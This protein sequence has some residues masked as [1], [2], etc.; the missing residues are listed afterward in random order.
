MRRITAAVR[1][2]L[3]AFALLSAAA[4]AADMIALPPQV[5]DAFAAAPPIGM[6][7]VRQ[8]YNSAVEN[9]TQFMVNQLQD[10]AG[11]CVEDPTNDWNMAFNYTSDGSTANLDFLATCMEKYEDAPSRLCS[12]AEVEFYIDNLINQA[13]SGN[14]SIGMTLNKSCNKTTWISGCEPGWACDINPDNSIQKLN[15]KDIPSRTTRC[16]PC[17]DGFFCPQGLTCMLPCPLGAYCHSAELD[18]STGLCTPYNYEI[19]AGR[20]HGCGGAN[21]WGLLGS[22][23]EIFCPEKSYC[24]TTVEKQTCQSGHYCRIGSTDQKRCSKLITCRESSAT[25]NIHLYGIMLIVA[26][27]A[28][29]LVIY[30]CSDHII[31]TRERRRA[32]SRAKAAIS[33]QQSEH[34]RNRWKA[35][36]EAAKK[37]VNR[38]HASLSQKISSHNSVEKIR[39]LD[40]EDSSHRNAS[41]FEV[42]SSD[43]ESHHGKSSK[44]KAPKE[45]GETQIFKN[46][47]AQMEKEKSRQQQKDKANNFA[48]VISIATSS[49][50]NK[51]PPI[52]V[53][54]KDLTL[55]LKGKKRCLLKSLTG[56]IM[57]GRIAAVMGPSGAGKTTLLTALAGKA[58]GC[59]RSGSILIN[60]ADVPIQSYKKIVGFVPQDDIVHGN[61]TVEEN[62]WFSARCRL[63]ADLRQADKILILERVIENLGLQEIRD[64]LVG[65]VEKRGISGGQKKRVNVG[66]ELVMEPSLLFL[67]EPTS[68]LDSSS[69]RLLLQALRQEAYAGV[70]IVMVVHQPS[71]ALFRMFDDLVLLAKGGLMVYQ[72]PVSRIEEYFEGIGIKV[73]DR[74]NPPDYYIDILEGMVEISTKSSL[75]YRQLPTMWMVQNGYPVPEDMQSSAADL[76]ISV[77]GALS[78]AD[79]RSFAGELWEDINSNVQL[80]QDRVYHNFFQSKD[81]SNRRTPNIY[82]QY[83]YFLGRLSKQRLREASLQATDYV[84]LLVAG[85]CVGAITTI[86][87]NDFGAALLCQVASLRTFSLDK[88]QYWRE[89]ASG[90]SSLAHFLAKDT[91]DHFNTVLKPVVYLSMFYFFTNP[92][93]S[94]VDNYTILI[95]L[96]YC[97]TGMGYAFSIFFNPGPAQLFSVLVPV[98][99]TLVSGQSI[100]RSSGAVIK[101]LARLSYPKYILE[102]FVIANA[103]RYYGVWLIQRCGVLIGSGFSLH[104]WKFCILI[105]VL[106][107]VISRLVAF[108]DLPATVGLSNSLAT[109]EV[110]S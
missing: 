12:Q 97:V 7:D 69:S 88:L 21:V 10:Q 15:T 98:C 35:A 37:N 9:F 6:S 108:A 64:S 39:M 5:M 8:F 46:V 81:L 56:K 16:Q 34:A 83:K 58:T 68:G 67:D 66:L 84:I 79:E 77:R 32:K 50:I 38:F 57:P 110:M 55:T 20:N 51:R 24:P 94:F 23:K 29:L 71:Y 75:N 53:A 41:S 54:F 82:F 61:L 106:F 62:L 73:P 14:G 11:A 17:C 44:K 78:S 109:G 99:M 42:E 102:A 60:G 40:A 103:K 92:R 31:S 19:P 33:V 101:F 26:M 43:A 27:I 52:E 48:E 76:D 13:K 22:S 96:V 105:V 91:L 104:A 3:L 65:T 86:S 4:S 70:N 89:S 85:A 95:S 25:Q 28:L 74:I 72:G 47:Y 36:R 90:I 1:L 87:D 63:S 49:Q 107:G 59:K 2:I 93:S 100:K 45:T 80:R 30:N 18:N